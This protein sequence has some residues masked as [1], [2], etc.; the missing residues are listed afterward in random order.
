MDDR[1]IGIFDSGLGGLSCLKALRRRLPDERLIYFGD[2]ARTPYGSKRPSTILSFSDE[3]VRFLLKQDVKLIM[4]ACNTVSS[5]CLGD[6][7]E[8][9]PELPFIGTIKPM[10]SELAEKLRED[11]RLGIIGTRVTIASD[12][13]PTLL[14]AARPEL[15]IVQ[16]ACPLF[17]PLV[18]EGFEHTELM[19]LSIR[20][21]MD[22]FVHEE[23][24]THLLLG[25]T[26]YP[27]IE[28]DIAKEY[29]E[30]EILDP[31]ASM[32]REVEET[33]KQRDALAAPP[34]KEK[35]IFFASDLS[36]NFVRMISSIM[37]DQDAH[38]FSETLG[39]LS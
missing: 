16:R 21:Y 6:L 23:R 18:E 3:I 4:I 1:P 8:R 26:H 10:V 14:H 25:C 24:L 31:A 2:T 30:L 29:P 12:M 32:A 17:V 37:G 34:K 5:T 36:E 33:L 13:Y 9:Y 35:D 39:G 20:H 7:E 19:R 15:Y 38:I 11:S 27:L 22:A 28:E